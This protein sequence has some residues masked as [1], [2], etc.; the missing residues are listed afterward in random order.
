MNMAV[1][2]AFLVDL[3]NALSL[4][5]IIILMPLGTG[6]LFYRRSEQDR[7]LVFLTGMVAILAAFELIYLPFFF[8][9]QS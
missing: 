3:F 7:G 6:Y 5:A 1:V 9:K 8:L 2:T 4:G